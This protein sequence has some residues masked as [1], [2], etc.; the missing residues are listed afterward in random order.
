M[1]GGSGL[2]LH[3]G[4]VPRAGTGFESSGT[5]YAPTAYNRIIIAHI[6]HRTLTVREGLG[7]GTLLIRKTTGSFDPVVFRMFS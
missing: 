2:M 5:A 1:S 4:G 6:Y 7:T 3:L